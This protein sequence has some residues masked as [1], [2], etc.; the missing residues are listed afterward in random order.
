LRLNPDDAV[1]R[2]NLGLMDTLK[3]QPKR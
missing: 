1:A 2:K 3:N